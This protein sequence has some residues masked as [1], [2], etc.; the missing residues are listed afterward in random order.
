MFRV[1]EHFRGLLFKWCF[2]SFPVHQYCLLV[3]ILVGLLCYFVLLSLHYYKYIKIRPWKIWPKCYERCGNEPQRLQTSY[4]PGVSRLCFYQTRSAWYM[5]Q[6]SNGKRSAVHNFAPTVT[7]FCVVWEGLS[8]P[9][10]TKFGNCRGEIVD[11]RM[12]F[13]WSLLDPWIR[14]IWFDK[15][16]ACYSWVNEDFTFINNFIE[17]QSLELQ[18]FHSSKYFWNVFDAHDPIPKTQPIYVP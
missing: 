11:R 7:K 2:I 10:D 16:R 6:G 12:I 18:I 1:S 8:L 3:C 5:D 9:H 13:I 14:L 15:S 4:F 17:W